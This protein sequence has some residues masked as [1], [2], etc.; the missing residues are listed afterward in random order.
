MHTALIFSVTIISYPLAS[1]VATGVAK[2]TCKG[3]YDN[4]SLYIAIHACMIN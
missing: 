1:Y 2:A 3:S 4:T